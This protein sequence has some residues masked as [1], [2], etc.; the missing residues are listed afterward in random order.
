MK[1]LTNGFFSG[2]FEYLQGEKRK[3]DQVRLKV[4]Q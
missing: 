1:G 2:V 4:Q 3:V